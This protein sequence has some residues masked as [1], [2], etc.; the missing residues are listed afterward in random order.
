MDIEQGV[1]LL[2]SAFAGTGFGFAFGFDDNGRECGAA[3]LSGKR[4]QLLHFVRLLSSLSLSLSLTLTHSLTPRDTCMAHAFSSIRKLV[5]HNITRIKGLGECSAST[6]KYLCS[7]LCLLRAFASARESRPP[8]A[9]RK[10]RSWTQDELDQ[11][12][13]LH[14]AGKNVREIRSSLN[15]RRSWSA[16]NE[17]LRSYRRSP[18]TIRM[19]PW[20]R[21][22]EDLLVIRR[23]QGNT[24]KSIAHELG[25]SRASVS[26]K[27]SMMR[28]R[29]AAPQAR[30]RRWTQD[31][32][33][34]ALVM[35]AEGWT[36][37]SIATV[38][39]R[40]YEAVRQNLARQCTTD[41]DVVNY[42]RRFTSA[43][44]EKLRSLCGKLSCF[45]HVADAMPDRL[46]G[47]LLLRAKT[48]GVW[49]PSGRRVPWTASEIDRLKEL[50]RRG[51][52]YKLC[53]SL[54][55]GRTEDA[56]RVQFARL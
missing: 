3:P 7:S 41:S 8:S 48:L 33:D 13:Q 1:N 12:W 30:R 28:P 24:S 49:K 50:R 40:S 16:I 56:I 34:R 51:V 5:W 35:R 10:G 37:Y 15:T 47:S 4:L 18:A 31:E 42:K 27:Y 17:V 54:L 45:R 44:D 38:L 29:E 20:T 39:G 26:T 52:S 32:V 19:N 55:P 6:K 53:A 14:S 46:Y 23:Q 22:E 25:R 9:E 2:V 43:E 21:E 36:H 11:L